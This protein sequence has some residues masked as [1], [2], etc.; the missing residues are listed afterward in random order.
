VLHQPFAAIIAL[1]EANKKDNQSDMG[2]LL[3]ALRFAAE[4]HKH[5]RRKDREQTPYIN[6]PIEVAERIC[7]VGG[8]FDVNVLCAALL[9]DTVEDTDTS[10]DEIEGL[11]GAEIAALVK[12][13]TDNKALPKAERKQQQIDHAPHLSFGAKHIKLADKTSNVKDIHRSQ[14]PDWTDERCV[15]Y[16]L[17]TEEVVSTIGG[18][19]EALEADYYDVLAQAKNSL[20]V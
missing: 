10:L 8:Y 20:K 12:E 9:H 2:L 14:P 15:E 19:N 1:V 16:L 6:H 13:V 5:Q 18:V 11:F 17:W 3:K 4:K 7:N